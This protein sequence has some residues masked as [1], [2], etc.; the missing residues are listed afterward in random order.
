MVWQFLQRIFISL[1]YKYNIEFTNILFH[2]TFRIPETFVSWQKKT[3]RIGNKQTRN[4]PNLDSRDIF[5]PF[6]K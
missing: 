1:Y 6:M 2:L 5:L 3:E 4:K